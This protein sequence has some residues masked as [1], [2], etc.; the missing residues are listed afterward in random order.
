MCVCVCVCVVGG[1]GGEWGALCDV[2]LLTQLAGTG[3]G[4][5]CMPSVMW[6]NYGRSYLPSVMNM[7][8]LL[9][10]LQVRFWCHMRFL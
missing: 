3:G 6:C 9:E 7:P 1:W 5:S 8:Q 4:R 2:I 10:F